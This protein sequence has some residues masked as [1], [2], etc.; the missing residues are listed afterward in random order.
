MPAVELAR[1]PTV[2]GKRQPPELADLDGLL[3]LSEQD[4]EAALEALAELETTL[5]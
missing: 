5:S 2:K 4:P 3:A 1:A